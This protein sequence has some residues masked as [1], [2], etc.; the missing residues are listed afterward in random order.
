M[1]GA[2]S[3]SKRATKKPAP[4]IHIARVHAVLDEL[5]FTEGDI[6][7]AVKRM[8]AAV[9]WNMLDFAVKKQMFALIMANSSQD[10]DDGSEYYDELRRVEIAK[11]AEREHRRVV[12]DGITRNYARGAYDK[13]ATEIAEL[14]A[15]DVKP[16]PAALEEEGGVVMTTTT[17]K[18]GKRSEKSIDPRLQ[19]VFATLEIA[20]ERVNEE[21]SPTFDALVHDLVERLGCCAL[22]PDGAKRKLLALTACADP[23]DVDVLDDLAK[24]AEKYHQ[25]LCH[26]CRNKTARAA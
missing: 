19:R 1:S 25:T 12:A 26:C 14:F 3:K 18:K 4:N 24:I 22:S 9:D 23:E 7:G 21:A 16:A 13:R 15:L 6:A 17:T 5:L 11:V 2:K 20:F 10:P 8:L